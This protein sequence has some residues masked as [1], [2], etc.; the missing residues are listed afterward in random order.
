MS[1]SREHLVQRPWDTGLNPTY[2]RM[3]LASC[4]SEE[5]RA[6]GD[7]AGMARAARAWWAAGRWEPWKAV[8]RGHRE[9]TF[10]Y[11]HGNPLCAVERT[12]CG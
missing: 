4:S 5:A 8:G 7:R 10:I 1:S 3:I 6:E 9:E 2:S 12:D 11:D